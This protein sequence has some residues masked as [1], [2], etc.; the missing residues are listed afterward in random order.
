MSLIHRLVEAI[1]SEC[2]SAQLDMEGRVPSFGVNRLASEVHELSL[3][4]LA[5]GG[6]VVPAECPEAT[7]KHVAWNIAGRCVRPVDMVHIGRDS[8][9]YS[10]AGLRAGTLSSAWQD[11]RMLRLRVPCRQCDDCLRKRRTKWGR[12]AVSEFRTSSRSWFGTLT[13]R[14]EFR[15]RL[16]AAVAMRLLAEGR[17]L[18]EL[19]PVEQFRELCKEAGPLVT[20]FLDRLRNG[21]GRKDGEQQ[22]IQFRYLLTVEPHADWFPHYHILIHEISDLMPIRENF[23]SAQWTHGHCKWRLVK[24][25]RAAKYVAKYLGKFSMARVRASK[26]Y[27]RECEPVPERI[28]F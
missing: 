6:V 16:K 12:G 9:E 1:S 25:D 2:L 13:F 15:Y 27:G 19:E 24:D 8:H 20:R 14:P 26:E 11:N 17:R 7:G 22:R 18:E 28:T 5:S 21:P 4:A 3:K 23:L 10:L